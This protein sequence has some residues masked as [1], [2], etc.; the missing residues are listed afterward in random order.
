[1]KLVS[2]EWLNKN[3]S[4]VKIIDASW[5]LDKQRN[6][7]KEYKKRTG[8]N[9]PIRID[10][11]RKGE[12]LTIDTTDYSKGKKYF[13]YKWTRSNYGLLG[14]GRSIKRKGTVDRKTTDEFI[15][16]YR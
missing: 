8:K 6:A 16:K 15:K 7:A 11:G 2:S 3:L 10:R 14:T 13:P 4:S 1:M 5:H 12:D 9:K